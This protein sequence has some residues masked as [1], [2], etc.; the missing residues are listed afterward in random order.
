MVN[1]MLNKSL[2]EN[3]SKPEKINVKSMLPDETDILIIGGGITGITTAYLLKNSNFKITIIDKSQIG[4]GVSANSTAKVSFLQK[5]IYQDLEKYFSRNI[6]KL[7]LDSQLEAIKIISNIIKKEKIDC[8]FEK[9][10]SFL[11]TT[12][13][14]NIKKLDKEKN[15]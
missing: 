5:T 8:D 11:F 6:S 1:I 13:K 7:Y 10:N 15:F 4:M 3:I 14:N 12:D 9:S 2:W